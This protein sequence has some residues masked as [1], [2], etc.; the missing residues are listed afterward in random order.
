MITKRMLVAPRT[1]VQTPMVNHMK[2]NFSFNN[3][4]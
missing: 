3:A 1:Q 4:G 2:R